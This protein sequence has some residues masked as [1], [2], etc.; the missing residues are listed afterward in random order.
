MRYRNPPYAYGDDDVPSFQEILD[1][2]D[3]FTGVDFD[4]EWYD[5]SYLTNDE[6]RSFIINIKANFDAAGIDPDCL[7]V[8]RSIVDIIKGHADPVEAYMFFRDAVFDFYKFSRF[9]MDTRTIDLAHARVLRTL[10]RWRGV[11]GL[12]GLPSVHSVENGM[13]VV[14]NKGRCNVARGVYKAQEGVLAEHLGEL[15]SVRILNLPLF[16]ESC[17]P[18]L[19]VAR[20]SISSIIDDRINHVMQCAEYTGARLFINDQLLMCI[21]NLCRAL[22]RIEYEQRSFV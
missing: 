10:L 4:C 1:T 13:V 16:L 2:F 7:C 14:E 20:A 19:P 9:P 8:S 5:V 6:T 17:V 22:R 12:D 15:F 21:K 11:V 3:V 18:L